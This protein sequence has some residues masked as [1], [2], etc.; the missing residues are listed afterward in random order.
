VRAQVF[1]YRPAVITA[2]TF[3]LPLTIR[4]LWLVD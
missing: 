3:T 2:A 4:P 1:S